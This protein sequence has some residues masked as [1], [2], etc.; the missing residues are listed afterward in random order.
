MYATSQRELVR[1]SIANVSV[2]TIACALCNVKSSTKSE[3]RVLCAS[4][5][6]PLTGGRRIR[7]R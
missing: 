4:Q 6:H 1:A 2:R 5:R 7:V 3:R